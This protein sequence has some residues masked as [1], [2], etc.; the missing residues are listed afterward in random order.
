MELAFNAPPS[1]SP[2]LSSYSFRPQ[3]WSSTNGSRDEILEYLQATADEYAVTDHFLPSTR[4]ASATWDDSAKRWAVALE[5]SDGSKQNK[6]AKILVNAT[7]LL[8]VPRKAQIANLDTFKGTVVHTA[9]W[10]RSINLQNKRVA[11]VGTGSSGTQLLAGIC[12]EP[13]IQ[14]TVFQRSFTGALPLEFK[15][16][17]PEEIADFK[18]HPEKLAELK[19]A[20]W[21]FFEHLVSNV[22]VGNP[23]LEGVLRSV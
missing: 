1:P 11:I 23:M 14:V 12:E 19:A 6:T 5:S 10:D 22:F 20:K 17:T 7:G 3:V 13:G 18:A 8:S 15:E 21:G 16:Y 4:V 9:E 2:N